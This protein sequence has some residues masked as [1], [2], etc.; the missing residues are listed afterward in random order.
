MRSERVLRN[1]IDTTWRSDFAYVI[2]MIASDGYLYKDVTRIGIQSKDR[3]MTELFRKALLIEN[4]IG[5]KARGGEQEKRYYYVEFKSRQFY[6]FLKNLGITPAKSKTI[7]SVT[8]PDMYFSDFLR[9]LFDGDGT[10]WS[11]WDKRWPNSFVF[12]I[13]FYSA[14]K[15]FM[16]WLLK[17]LSLLYGVKGFIKKGAGVFEIRYGKGDSRVLFEKMYYSKDILFL[18]RK[19]QKI[20]EALDL[21]RKIKQNANHAVVAQW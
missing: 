13:A 21:D 15:P 17:R 7:Q 18:N 10:F 11:H 16:E 4:K 9:G 8:V 3:E 2:G 1:I 14:S 19:Y 5:R 6:D 20:L 12:H